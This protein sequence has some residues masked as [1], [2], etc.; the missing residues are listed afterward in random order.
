MF[1]NLGMDELEMEKS[2]DCPA[3]EDLIWHLTA[4]RSVHFIGHGMQ[5]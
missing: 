2:L 5:G 1:V 3:R 4:V